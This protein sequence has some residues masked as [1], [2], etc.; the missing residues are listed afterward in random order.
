M[1]LI[2]DIMLTNPLRAAVKCSMFVQHKSE[3]KRCSSL[4]SVLTEQ[5]SMKILR[6][7][8]VCISVVDLTLGIIIECM[9]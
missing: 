7:V 5:S 3:G 1:F 2:Q 4:S 8:V 6:S 9:S